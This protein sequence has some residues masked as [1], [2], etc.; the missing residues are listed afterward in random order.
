MQ[1]KYKSIFKN[2][3][4]N[5][6]K[7]IKNSG[8]QFSKCRKYRYALW[9]IWDESKPLVMYIGLNPSKANEEKTDNTI[10]RVIGISKSLGY[11][12]I[13]MMN[14]FPYVST[15][16]DDLK[17]FGNTALNDHWLYKVAAKCQD[18]IFAWGRFKVAKNRAVEL[19]GMFPDAKC[20][21]KNKDGTPRHP[22]YIK[23]NTK[24]QPFR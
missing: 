9:R 5:S 2:A 8:A 11:G 4:I 19:T 14:C 21:I 6:M 16:P 24:P 3:R 15:N 10:T 18:I 20:L 1:T 12:G 13:Y 23:T 7:E 22:L 17:D